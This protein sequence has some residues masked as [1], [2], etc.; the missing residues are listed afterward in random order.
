MCACPCVTIYY[1]CQTLETYR[2]RLFIFY[3]LFGYPKANFGPLVSE[4]FIHIYIYT[5]IYIYL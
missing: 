2:D 4:Y 5:Y 3:Q 1:K